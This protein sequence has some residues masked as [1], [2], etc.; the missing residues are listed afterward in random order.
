M[1]LFAV[2]IDGARAAVGI[3]AIVY[4]LAGIGLNL[5]FGYGGLLNFGHVGFL[6]VGAYGTGIAVNLGRG[7]SSPPSGSA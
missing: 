3:P 1:D 7:R 5:Q 4:A 2:F 6:L